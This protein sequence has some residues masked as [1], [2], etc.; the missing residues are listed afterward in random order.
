[1]YVKLFRLSKKVI[2]YAIKANMQHKLL[3]IFTAFIYDVQNRLKLNLTDINNPV[4]VRHKGRPHKR[5]VVSVKK[6]LHKEKWVLENSSNIN[7]IENH[8]TSYN[9]ED[10]T[11]ITKGQK[12]G[13]YNQYG[14]Y[15]KTCQNDI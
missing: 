14:Y 12:C 15:A 5:L 4:I 7:V 10:F 2:D 1:M 3:N 11:N 13:K 8:S 9:R 6:G